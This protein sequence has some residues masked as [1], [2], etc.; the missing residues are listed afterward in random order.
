MSVERADPERFRPYWSEGF[1][2]LRGLFTTDDVDAWDAECVRLTTRLGGM[3]EDSRLH[4]RG[5]ET[6]GS[7]VDRI[8]P[9]TDVSSVFDRLA[10]DEGLRSVARGVLRSDV[11]LMKDRLIMKRSGTHGYGLHQDFPYWE[12]CGVPAD[13]IV[14]VIVSIDAADEENG[15]IEVFPGMHGSRLPGPSD[16]PRDV[17]PET[18]GGAAS[19]LV[20]TEPGDVLLMHPLT[21]HRSAPNRT[22]RTRRMDSFIYVPE[23]H[24]MTRALY[25]G[26][27]GRG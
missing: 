24:E 5:H 8:D 20:A 17:D 9:V 14:S 1:Q 3:R 18:L 23:R 4:V 2:V 6:E 22:S 11:V 21:P 12:S 27:R 15:G 7:I 25:Y 10:K 16:E 26:E 13:E 19:R